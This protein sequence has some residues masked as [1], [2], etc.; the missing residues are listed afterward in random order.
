M[1]LKVENVSYSYGKTEALID[2]SCSVEK[3]TI[4]GIMGETGSGK[5]TLLKL[6]NGLNTLQKGKIEIDGVSLSDIP[7]S[8]LPFMV[9]LVFQS[10]ESQLFEESVLK[11][12]CYGALNKGL[13]RKEAEEKAKEALHMV[14]LGEEKWGLS[15]FS[16][17]GGEKRRA[18]LAGVLVMDSEILV[19]DEIAAGLDKKGKDQIFS[20]LLSLKKMGKTIIFVSH[21]SD[22]VA[23]YADKVLILNKGKVVIEGETK[24]VF[25]SPYCPKP[26]SEVISA[27]LRDMD[28]DIPYPMLSITE[29][30]SFLME[31][32]R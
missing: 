2:V 21:D 17:S 7:P 1:K 28:V 16:L 26:H 22:D 24:E 3:G 10:P 31:K 18:A 12:V 29:L 25:S 30:S 13:G 15:P 23:L 8:S 11:D 4:Y 20:I 14:G 9:G 27:V 19:L 6:L 5:S 32:K